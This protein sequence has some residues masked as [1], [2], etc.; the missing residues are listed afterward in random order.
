MN[1]DYVYGSSDASYTSALAVDNN[2]PNSYYLTGIPSWWDK[3]TNGA[4]LPWPAIGPDLKT[5]KAGA[6]PA[7]RRWQ[8]YAAGGSTNKTLLFPAILTSTPSVTAP[9]NATITIKQGL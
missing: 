3:D 1:W 6:N 5:E 7:F 2:L 4:Y 9:S 8:A